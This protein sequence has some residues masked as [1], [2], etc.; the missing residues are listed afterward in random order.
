[1]KAK[2]NLPKV[3][4]IMLQGAFFPLIL[5]VDDLKD[6][7]LMLHYWVGIVVYDALLMFDAWLYWLIFQRQ[8]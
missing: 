1:M 2:T 8:K 7:G 3:L 4:Y 6:A 5:Q